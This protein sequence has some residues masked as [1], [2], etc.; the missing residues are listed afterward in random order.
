MGDRQA[1]QRLGVGPQLVR[2]GLDGLG[3]LTILVGRG[4]ELEVIGELAPRRRSDLT[5][6]RSHG[7]ENHVPECL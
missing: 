3:E 2:R 1:E 5:P 4:R 6:E 7:L